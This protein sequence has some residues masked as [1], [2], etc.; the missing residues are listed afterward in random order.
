MAFSDLFFPFVF[1]PISLLLYAVTPKKVKNV[2]LLLCSLVFFAW[3]TPEYLLLMLCSILVNYFAGWELHLNAERPARAKVVL[4]VTTVLNLLLLGFFKYYGFLLENLNA[5][6]GTSLPVRTL[7]APIGL[8]FYT[9]T[10][11]SYL[12]DVYRGKAP[13]QKNLF[14]FSLYVT[15]FPKLVSGPIIQY[16]DMEEQLSGRSLQ[17]KQ[18][19]EGAR[20]F[21]V[22]LGK[23]VLLANM[24]GTP[25]YALSGIGA[26]SLSTCGAW[27]GCL[28]YS[29]MLYFDFS[30]YSDMAVGVAKMFGYELPKNFDYPYLS[31]SVS[32]FWR[33]WH[34]TLGAWFRD[35]VY[36]PLGG[37]REGAGKTVRNLLIVWLLTGLWHGANWTFLVWGV[38]Y[39]LLLVLEKFVFRR[40]LEHIP[41]FFKHLL[42][43]LLVMIGWVFFFSD[44]LPE[45]LR[46]VGRMFSGGSVGFLD[47]TAK[48]YFASCWKL[49]LCGV[50]AC[51]P[52]GSRLGSIVYRKGKGAVAISAVYFLLILVLC[53]ASMMNDTYSSFL[54]F[55]F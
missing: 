54:Y 22:G 31:G 1:L 52:A 9:F 40:V 14:R 20:L 29:L 19:G 27:L 51:L 2:V 17:W 38:Y 3:G 41:G 30:G 15:F 5:L 36:I 49:L 43:L 23:K 53:I 4:T 28:C 26:A 42:T 46:W 12:F 33:R 24:L 34:I 16:A 8:S 45:A 32:E 10:L 39:G 48:Y 35:Y 37:S 13:M 11:L 55:Q 7:P 18:V 21:I 25:F 47:G 44:S 50:I 6:L